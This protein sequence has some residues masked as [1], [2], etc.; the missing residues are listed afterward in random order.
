MSAVAELPTVQAEAII[1]ELRSQA[2]KLLG[3]ALGSKELSEF[4]TGGEGNFPYYWQ[5]P[6]NLQFNL[7]TLKWINSLLAPD[8]VPYEFAPG[9]TFTNQFIKALAAISYSLSKA[10][11]TVLNDA[12][13]N[14]VDQ[15]GALLRQWNEIYGL[16]S[17]NHPIDEIMSTICNEWASEPPVTLMDIQS[18]T[19]LNQLLGNTP[20]SG[21]PILPLLA[22]YLN[23]LGSAVSLQNAVSLNNG[24]LAKA[25]DAV[26]NPSAKNGGLTIGSET[27]PAWEVATPISDII[28]S[29]KSSNKIELNTEVSRYDE[30]Q[31]TVSVS[32]GTGFRIPILSF[33]T[34]GIGGNASYFQDEIAI[35][36]NSISINMTYSGPTLVQYAP[37]A[38]E[39]STN[40]NWFFMEP[41]LDAIKNKDNDVSGFKF[42]PNPQIDFDRNGDFG[43][44][45]GVAIANYPS[46][47][48]KVTGSNYERIEKEF[49]Q[50]T[51]VKMSFLGIPLGS[52][53]QS[54]Y[55]H[56]V[57]VDASSQSVTITLDPPAELVAGTNVDSMGWILGA[58]TEFPGA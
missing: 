51:K 7:K 37:L 15:Q 13:S 3:T 18:A 55:K 1:A 43:L 21:K 12:N 25:L 4:A 54:T 57:K 16:P 42:S 9:S 50:E 19:N 23:A 28:N 38:F 22:N 52:A 35:S 41:I 32:G 26:Q 39:K 30:E 2:S 27:Y 31:F 20:A 47:V 6:N 8:Q 53:S 5:N 56:S 36:E 11:Q 14:A 29:L 46:I 33:F 45:S 40:K 44:T 49:R 34:L 10:D 17:G 58:I 24:Y 48:I